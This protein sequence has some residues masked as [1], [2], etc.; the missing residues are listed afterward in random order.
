MFCIVFCV[1]NVIFICISLS[2]FTIFLV[3]FPLYIRMA[4]FVFSVVNRFVNL[5]FVGRVFYDFVYIIIIVV[6]CVFIMFS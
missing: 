6:Y 3:S 4:H 2:S 5:V 1:L